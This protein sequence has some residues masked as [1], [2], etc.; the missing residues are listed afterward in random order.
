MG[1]T[2]PFLSEQRETCGTGRREAALQATGQKTG[3]RVQD[4]A[5][6]QPRFMDSQPLILIKKHRLRWVIMLQPK[7]DVL[8]QQLFI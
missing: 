5:S 1:R 2:T 7:V 6:S 3:I 4:K 8:E